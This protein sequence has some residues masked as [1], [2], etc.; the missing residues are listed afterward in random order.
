ML[1]KKSSYLTTLSC[2][3]GRYR[4]YRLPLHAAPAGDMFECKIDETFKEPPN[5]FGIVDDTLIVCYDVDGKDHDKT[6]T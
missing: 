1:Y 3:F 4:Y 6:Q 2:Q 5:V